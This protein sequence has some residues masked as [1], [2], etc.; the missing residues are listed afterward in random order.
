M[1]GVILAAFLALAHTAAVAAPVVDDR[2]QTFDDAAPARRIV[3]LAPHLAE[4]LFD[5]GAGA[6]LVGA[7]RGADHP[8]AAARVPNVGDAAGIDLERVLALHPDLVLAWG[9]GNRASDLSRLEALG[10]RV[11]VN[12][13]RVLADV[14]KTL[15]RLGRLT[16][17]SR[18]G[19]RA[20]A[21]FDTALA[22]LE[23]TGADAVPAF[24]Q[25]WDR[26]LM[27][28]SGAHLI[29][30]A[31]HHCGGRN[32]FAGLPALAGSVSREAVLSA[33]PAAILV[34]APP[35]QAREWV[36]AWSAF[37]AMNGRAL[38]ALNPDLLTRPTPR[39][40]RGVE[41]VCATIAAVQRASS[42][43]NAAA[44]SP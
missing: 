38:V 41:Q 7:V 1:R 17:R 13:P 18:Q 5:V 31:L 3:A 43:G 44:G 27:T 35:A 8:A 37:E 40:L 23:A 9:S 12:E 42:R 25:I 28:V 39:L 11:F 34:L 2:G 30:Q 19:E 22:A 26:P 32:V 21:A 29:S 4:L 33:R 24:V 15:R 14:G 6:A 20:A 36:T 16:G 10:L